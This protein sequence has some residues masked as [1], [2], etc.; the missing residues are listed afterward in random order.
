[1]FAFRLALQ[2]GCTV[3]ELCFRLSI[4]EFIEWMAFYQVEPWGDSV[5]GVRMAVNTAAVYNAGL[6]M[7]DPKRLRT[8]PFYPKQFFV[9]INEGQRKV[10]SWQDQREKLNTLIPSSKL[11]DKT[12]A[13]NCR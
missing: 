13:F 12:D 11:K 5:N 3:E 10:S 6:M 8:N 9:G 4:K 2:L 1:L 7:A